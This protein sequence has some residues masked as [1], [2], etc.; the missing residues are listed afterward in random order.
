MTTRRW[1]MEKV[2]LVTG[3]KFLANGVFDVMFQ[4]NQRFSWKVALGNVSCNVTN[5][6]AGK[7]PESADVTFRLGDKDVTYTITPSPVVP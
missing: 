4:C 5:V 7:H 6:D 2:S 1:Q 3:R